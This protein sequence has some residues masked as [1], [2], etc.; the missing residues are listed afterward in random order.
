MRRGTILFA[1]LVMLLSA[2]GCGGGETSPPSKKEFA[3]QLKLACD[4]GRQERES[5]L[6]SISKEYYEDREERATPKY[7]NEN[8]LKVI[9][10]Y[11][12]TTDKIAALS[13]PTAEEAKLES[14]VRAREEAAAKV[15]ASPAGTRDNLETIFQKPTEASEAL[16]AGTC[17]I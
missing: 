6:K 17:D 16:G 5:L 13:A 7:Q 10:S 8:L 1:V 11:Q 14:F 9:A 2:A 3:K 12:E 4:K 15:E